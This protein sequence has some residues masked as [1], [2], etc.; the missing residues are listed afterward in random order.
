[1]LREMSHVI[2]LIN[3]GR[4]YGNSGEREPKKS[5]QQPRA[6]ERQEKT[7]GKGRGIKGGN[8]QGRSDKPR[9]DKPKEK[10]DIPQW[11]KDQGYE[12]KYRAVQ[13]LPSDIYE[14]RWTHTSKNKKH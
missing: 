6:Q 12:A 1:M 11:V 2:E 10:G 3:K 8:R 5:T 13:T 4:N 9:T 7:S 14:K